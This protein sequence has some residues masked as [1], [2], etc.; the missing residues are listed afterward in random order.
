FFIDVK[1]LYLRAENTL[2][3]IPRHYFQTSDVFEGL[4]TLP[5]VPNTPQE[6]SSEECPLFLESIKADELKEFLRVLCSR[7][8]EFATSNNPSIRS[9]AGSWLPV[10]KLAS[11]W[12]F[13]GLRE[14]ALKYLKSEGCM[15]R[16][17]VAR[18]YGVEDW[19]LPALKDLIAREEPL[20]ADEINQLGVDF[21]VKVIA[22]REEARG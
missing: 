17:H 15:T 20:T 18:Q 3:C 4:F 5:E 13:P 2:F 1:P 9:I 21:A 7:R 14:K 8:V 16:L 19:F 22:L 11:L 12:Q 10:L 6:G